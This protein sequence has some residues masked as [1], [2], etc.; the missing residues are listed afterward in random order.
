MAEFVARAYLGNNPEVIPLAT[1]F[2]KEER[3]SL[4]PQLMEDWEAHGR[5]ATRPGF[6]ALAVHRFGTWRMGIGPRVIR[7]PLSVLYRAMYRTVRNLYGIELPYTARVGRRVIIEHQSG[8]VIH[9]YAEIGDDCVIHQDVTIGNRRADRP[10]DA[11][12]LGNRVMVGAGAKLL[13]AV[14]V[15]DDAQIGANAVVC[16]DVP[17][18]AMAVGV[19]A[20]VVRGVLSVEAVA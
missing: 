8:V 17:A 12:R 18:G 5:D 1:K 3:P 14:Q 13:G 10:L 2:L 20:R 9:G 7:A 15:G 6:Q 16:H 4:I 11:P 19:P